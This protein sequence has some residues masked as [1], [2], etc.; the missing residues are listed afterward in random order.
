MPYPSEMILWGGTGQAKVLNP[1]IEYFGSRVIAV[2]NDFPDADPP[3]AGVPLFIGLEAFRRW[4]ADKDPSQLG[5][6]IA[7]GNPHGRIRLKLHDGL[8]QAGL[9]PVTVV[10]PTAWVASNAVVGEGAQIMAG[11]IV[12]AEA[13]VGRQCIINTNASVDHEVILGEGSEV[14][15]GATVCGS[16][17]VGMN[18]W[19]CAGA[20]V[21][22]FVTIGADAVV[23]AGAVVLQDVPAGTTVVGIPAKPIGKKTEAAQ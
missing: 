18:A 19:I 17:K 15:P 20:V 10:H 4:I 12:Q 11:A 14:A 3:L 2:F 23:G 7:I 8:V 22:P 21:V 13:R 5:F 9:T 6:A 16:V 1:I